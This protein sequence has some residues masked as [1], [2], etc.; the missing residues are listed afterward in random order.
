MTSL[1]LILLAL[2]LPSIP[3]VRLR[4]HHVNNARQRRIGNTEACSNARER[5]SLSGIELAVGQAHADE[6]Q[7]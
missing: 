1:G 5:F 4:G 7:K 3:K 2:M 6:K